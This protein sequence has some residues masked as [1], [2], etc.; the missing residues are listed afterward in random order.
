[1]SFTDVI[2][3]LPEGIL[4]CLIIVIFVVY[5]VIGLLLVQ[6]YSS[7]SMLKDHN[8][9]TA[10]LV[11]TVG[12]VFAVLI[13]FLVVNLWQ[14][15]DYAI[16]TTQT[17]AGLL[18][19]L[20]RQA[21]GYPESFRN[22]IRWEIEEYITTV[23]EVEWPILQK[24]GQA[25][26][27]AWVQIEKIEE[28]IITFCPKNQVETQTEQLQL[29]TIKAVIDTRRTRLYGAVSGF[30]GPVW[31]VITASA[32]LT[33]ASTWF[34]GSSYFLPHLI[35]VILLG[36]SVGL[37]VYLAITVSNPFRGKSGISPKYFK[38]VLATMK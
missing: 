4:A 18:S 12:I 15:Y 23:I 38:A 3:S 20:W 32:L 6:K 5:S 9:L 33:I 19:D 28:Q 22:Q 27:L 14:S 10:G 37:L 35:G 1:M 36:I 31:F 16:K 26:S 34:F 29:S 2:Y 30:T 25:S 21:I 11:P 13:G 8:D 17:E 24:G 7:R